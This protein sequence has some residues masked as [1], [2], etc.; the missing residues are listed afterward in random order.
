MRF[1]FDE[2]GDFSPPSNGTEHKSSVVVGV[3]IPELIETKVF[4]SYDRFVAG[5]DAAEFDRSEP[6][7]RRLTE[8]S[9]K[10]F[11]EA[12]VEQREV[13]ITPALLD[14]TTL[15]NG[16]AEAGIESLVKKLNTIAPQCTY[17][18]L[19]N[20]VQL[21]ARQITNLSVEQNLR[22][23]ATAR[24]LF[25]TL[26]H[27]ILFHAGNEYDACW[28]NIEVNI[29]PV[30]MQAGGRERIVFE[31][32]MLGWIA[33]WTRSDKIMMVNEIHTKDHP[34]VQ[35][36]SMPTGKIDLGALLRD[37]VKWTPSA[38]S[39]GIQIADMCATI[40]AQATRRIVMPSDLHNYGTL[41][42]RNVLA[43]ELAPGLFTVG[44]ED[45]DLGGRYV[46]LL[47]A[48]KHAR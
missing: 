10:R 24:S 4:D 17:E 43:P 11:C 25:H 32:M 30:Q 28:E 1:Y 22:I 27:C 16:R 23:L 45:F 2:S 39:R 29:D 6:K 14:L 47:D 34:F 20:E 21:L 37:R 48:I 36:Y 44:D 33:A 42:R 26:K 7:G 18:T 40:N 12:I 35:K 46:G 31:R 41:M 3:D 15:A 9:R 19:A 8:E 13:I 38:S 5:L